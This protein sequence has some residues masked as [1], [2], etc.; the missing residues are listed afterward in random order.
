MDRDRVLIAGAGP[1]GLTLALALYRAGV[2]V[3]VFEKR[4]QLNTASRAST[5]HPPSLAL[6]DRLGVLRPLLAHG[7]RVDRVA[8]LRAGQGLAAAMDFSLL[9]GLTPFPF[10]WHFEQA[11]ATPSLLAALP[12]GMVRFGTAVAGLETGGGM[13]ALQLADGGRE[14]GRLAVA[15]DGA[16]SVL[17]RSAGI[18][19]ETGAYGHRVLRLVTPLALEALLPGLDRAGVAYVFD[20]EASV[21]LL[22]M[23]GAWRIIIRIPAATDDEAA[24]TAAF[25]TPILRR[26][27]P[28]LPAD[29]ALCGMDV[30]GVAKGI[31]A[32]MRQGPVVVVGDAAHVTNTR[33]GMNMN[34]GLHD[35]ATL[36][37]TIAAGGD[38][39]HWAE[40]R[41]R[42]TREVLLER[43]DRA[44]ATGSAWL[45]AAV[46]AAASPD[47]A[48]AWLA[49]GAMLDT[50]G[51]GMP[52]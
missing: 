9:A 13:V 36:A 35:A 11:Q 42:V 19:V 32:T 12:P 51:Q 5:W 24:R 30:Y 21:S 50:A 2:P 26:F 33:G 1:V 45:A 39:G 46:Q 43:T 15:A 48:R 52:P 29:L 3:A 31:A 16:H 20:D 17:R 23:P 8:W 25:R 27:F 4:E 37:A 10:R 41:E 14:T 28:E 6:L 44:V 38:L 7:V 49:A 22:R 40:A 47:A 34:A 18:A